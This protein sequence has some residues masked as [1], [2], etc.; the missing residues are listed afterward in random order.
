MNLFAVL[1]TDTITA[2]N[3][4]AKIEELFPVDSLRIGN[5][6]WL[7]ASSGTAK[8]LSDKLGI[9]DGKTGVAVVLSINGYYGHAPTNIWEWILAKLEA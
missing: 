6:Q 8:E 7:I 4:N 5:Q 3:I 9:T 2:E 1:N